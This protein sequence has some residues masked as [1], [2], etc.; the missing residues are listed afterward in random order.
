VRNEIS[1]LQNGQA[2]WSQI[3]SVDV[4][5][6]WCALAVSSGLTSLK[7]DAAAMMVLATGAE[8]GLT[9]MQALRSIHV[10]ES[11]GRAKL[12]LS[13]DLMVGLV[14]RSPVC[15]YFR[16]IESDHT[17]ATYETQRDGD[18]EPTHMTWSLDQAKRAGLTNR[19]TWKSYPEAM[20]RARCAASLARA[21]YPDITM[22]M[23][24]V[25][26][27][28]PADTRA[29]PMLPRQST[30]TP[31]ASVPH[32]EPYTPPLK[33]HHSDVPGIG[34][35]VGQE[36]HR[37]G[38]HDGQTLLSFLQAAGKVD[39][40][41][42]ANRGKAIDFLRTHFEIDVPALPPSRQE[43]VKEV[44][45][46]LLNATVKSVLTHI[47]DSMASEPEHEQAKVALQTLAVEE[48][49]TKSNATENDA[50]KALYK[51]LLESKANLERL[52]IMDVAKAWNWA[53][54]NAQF[55]P[56]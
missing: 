24:S 13:A 2:T 28:T 42:T 20:L 32:V 23:Y 25:D 56:F 45:S 31:P 54:T 15:K 21:V 37:I 52:T 46:R 11:K 19:Q 36:L 49:L 41:N 4:A 1:K 5:K 50:R 44:N 39:G 7:S 34:S 6:K 53:V 51:G 47:P 17:K 38:V 48:S 29:E 35:K 26:E 8:L 30:P 12:C 16:I 43:E 27:M 9:P 33:W 22:G 10:I 18:P 40:L 14:K 3:D 55:L